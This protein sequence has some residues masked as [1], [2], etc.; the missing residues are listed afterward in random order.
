MYLYEEDRCPITK[1]K[2][3]TKT[4]VQLYMNQHL[5]CPRRMSSCARVRTHDTQHS[6]RCS[7]SYVKCNRRIL[8][9]SAGCR[10][11]RGVRGNRPR[12]ERGRRG[13]EQAGIVFDRR[14][15]SAASQRPSNTD[16]PEER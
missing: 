1:L 4:R 6:S 16:E 3:E 9:I 11:P 8:R 5:G 13:D 15:V 12:E 14:R 7:N 10:C 2:S